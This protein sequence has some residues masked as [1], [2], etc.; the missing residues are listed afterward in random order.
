MIQTK[1]PVVSSDK[2]RLAKM[3][4]ALGNPI[5]FQI[6]ETLAERQMCITSEIVRTRRRAP[7]VSQHPKVP[8]RVDPRRSKACTCYRLT[9]TTSAGRIRSTRAAILLLDI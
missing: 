1:I 8:G 6:V 2:L 5:R 9:W 3:L 4:K 7:T